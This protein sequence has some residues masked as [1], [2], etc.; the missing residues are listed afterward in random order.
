[1][2]ASAR[3]LALIHP[4]L[5]HPALGCPP[6]ETKTSLGSKPTPPASLFLPLEAVHLGEELQHLGCSEQAIKGLERLLRDAQSKLA[7]ECR[8]AF[9]EIVE[10]LTIDE[11]EE[12]AAL[13]L[14][15]SSVA[16]A[17]SSRFDA[18]AK[19]VRNEIVQQVR[20]SRAR[21]PP[22]SDSPQPTTRD[23]AYPLPEPAAEPNGAFTEEV[24]EILRR[25]FE[26]C[27]TLTRGEVK[28]L[29]SI[30]KLNSK[31]IRTWFANQRQRR[32]RKPAP[33]L[34]PRRAPASQTP[35]KPFRNVSNSSTSSS[36]ISYSSSSSDKAHHEFQESPNAY[37][38]V[39][40]DHSHPLESRMDVEDVPMPQLNSTSPIV[41]YPRSLSIPTETGPFPMS[42]I[43]P[44]PTTAETDRFFSSQQFASPLPP[45]SNEIYDIEYLP[46]QMPSTMNSDFLDQLQRTDPFLD[47]EFLKNVFGT[48]GVTQGGGLTLTMDS[49]QDE[50]E[51]SSGSGGSEG[52][53]GS[54]EGQGPLTMEFARGGAG[55]GGPAGGFAFGW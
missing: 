31:Q 3:L 35:T 52:R 25:A 17:I 32:G 24:I 51:M 13:Q 6:S 18:E 48:L 49:F 20:E 40:F 8:R 2:D 1:M 42:S 5:Q 55:V 11:E 46:A 44:A 36:L 28:G 38:S 43:P 4:I 33:Y 37:S 45:R 7:E 14:W 29:Q 23:F 22:Y 9:F 41:E 34:P 39:D 27:E 53:E 26:K 10:G 30:T 16:A 47:D 19:A 54:Q 21:Q 50:G 12:V 15:I